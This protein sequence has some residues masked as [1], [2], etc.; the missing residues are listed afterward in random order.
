MANHI[1]MLP[2][3][4]LHA[5]LES[6]ALVQ[7]TQTFFAWFDQFRQ[8]RMVK[9]NHMQRQQ[10]E[11][12]ANTFLTLYVDDR[13]Q[14]P[15]Q[16]LLPFIALN[17]TIANF[18]G[19]TNIGTTDPWIQTLMDKGASIEKMLPLYSLRNQIKIGNDRLF[20]TNPALASVWYSKQRIALRYAVGRNHFQNAKQYFESFPREYRIVSRDCILAGYFA[21]TYLH[22]DYERQYK[23]WLINVIQRDCERIMPTGTPDTNSIALIS[24]R[25]IH[26]SAVHRALYP[27][28]KTLKDKYTLTLV[29]IGPM[30]E[31]VDT[32]LFSEI[33]HFPYLQNPGVLSEEQRAAVTDQN[34]Q[35]A[36][37]PDVGMDSETIYLASQRIAPVQIVGY[38]HPSSTWSPNA[39]YF[40]VGKDVECAKGVENT[41]S[42]QLVQLPGIGMHAVWP[43]SPRPN[44]PA[45]KA[46]DSP[47]VINCPWTCF[48]L[49]APQ[50]STLKKILSGSRR[51][52]LLRVFGD[53]GITEAGAYPLY[54]RDLLRALGKDNVEFP[55]PVMRGD[56]YREMARG[57]ITLIAYPFGGFTTVIDSIH[58]G[59]PVITRRG[60]QG[61]NNF[62]AELLR[63]YGLDELIAYSEE[64]YVD[65]TVR[66]ANDADYRHKL[67]STLFKLDLPKIL[68][69]GF[70]GNVFER[71]IEYVLKNHNP[72]K[73][74]P[75]K[76][77]VVT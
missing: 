65:K 5:L 33:R 19:C 16:F 57:D 70:D 41:F 22:S 66:L 6:N 71:A 60:K 55:P 69:E 45:D 39:D 21:V 67:Q 52:I 36:Y 1:S 75:N 40:F 18:I 58:L 56:Y 2:V 12:F 63:K 37:F 42:E 8:A 35:I 26:G 54:K 46:N 62:P 24:S 47:I 64:E 53:E 50:I 4:Q 20:A 17:S 34:W 9:Y 32:S 13:Y 43:A 29:H 25:W 48:K 10:M 23:S 30:N 77:I 61:Y 72:S 28:F 44:A 68:S 76:P 3:S 11:H 59:I 14:I 7:L 73:T 74:Q 49:A 31:H 38:G 27:Y 51:K 15:Q